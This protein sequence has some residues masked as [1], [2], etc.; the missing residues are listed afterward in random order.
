NV[1]LVFTSSTGSNYASPSFNGGATIN[2]TAPTSGSTQ[3][4]VMF[5]DRNMPTGT[6]FKF[7]GGASQTLTGAIYAPKAD[8]SYAGG[9]DTPS[10][11]TKLIANTVK[12]TGNSTFAINCSGVG[13][14]SIG[15]TIA[16]LLQ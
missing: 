4:I 8:V 6:A 13:T 5:G 9:S 3:G 11:C 2:L 10:G 16:R 1:T 15:T 14:R 12:F 7:E